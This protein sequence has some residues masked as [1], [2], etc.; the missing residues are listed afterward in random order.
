MQGGRGLPCREGGG[1]VLEIG[2]REDVEDVIGE[3]QEGC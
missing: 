2:K 1:G 3:G